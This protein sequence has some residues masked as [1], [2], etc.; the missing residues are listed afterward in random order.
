MKYYSTHRKSDP[1]TYENAV[2]RGLAAD[3]GLFFPGRIDLLPRG[4][5]GNGNSLHEL[6]Y[7]AI[8]Q[9][10]G[11]DIPTGKL[12]AIVEE[13]L[14]FPLPI[15][16]IE[17]DVYSLELWHGP[18]CAFK[19]IG[20]RFLA[21]NLSYF[22]RNESKTVTVLVATSGDT[23]SA[24]A[25]GFLDVEG[26]QVVI[27]Y[28][29]GKV[30][31]IQEKQLTTMGKNIKS[32]EV[33]GTFDDCQNMVKQAFN[34][35]E[36]RLNLNLSSANSINVARFLPQMF[37][38]FWAFEQL[39]DK[40]KPLTF[41]VP[42]GNF[43]NLTAGLFA[44]KLGL[45][46]HQFIASTNINDVVP[47]YLNTGIY[48]PRPS[49]S[50]KSNAMDIGDPS[51]FSRIVELYD[52]QINVLKQDMT[53]YSFTDGDAIQAMQSVF[54]NY[55]YLMDPHG[56]I[57][58]AGLKKWLNKNNGQ[59]IFLETAHPAKFF[60]VVESAID[61]AVEIPERLKEYLKLEKKST[62]IGN[63]FI[64]LKAFLLN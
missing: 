3:K 35:S 11:T 4:L 51:N 8:K 62:L 21:R 42:S 18:T 58:Y 29:S 15:I 26:I 19:D 33:K 57:A 38:Y 34:D 12:Q 45:P 22:L 54:Q 50:T 9:F 28:P 13:V 39:S 6:S 48:R 47:E 30:S 59:G 55:G 10:V 14:N 23:G 56:A 44:K 63:S 27:L 16:E 36:L 7:E 64:E 2:I 49:I 31:N 60:E 24:V 20:A 40:K 5:V 25:S 32:L 46:V 37:Y 43:G 52:H 17:T 53:G 1:V 41:S 61:C